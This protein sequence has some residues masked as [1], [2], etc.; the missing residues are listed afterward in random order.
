[1][2][3]QF[4]GTG[5]AEHKKPSNAVRVHIR[6]NRPNSV[7]PKRNQDESKIDE[8][9]EGEDEIDQAKQMFR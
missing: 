7:P 1:V 3:V 9:D 2:A 4:G 8:E 6:Q 5:S